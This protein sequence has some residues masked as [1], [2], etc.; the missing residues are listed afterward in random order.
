MIIIL[1]N[2]TGNI[3]SVKNMLNKI[4]I[5]AKVSN[6]LDEIKKAEKVIL[7]GV[8]SFD[9]GIDALRNSDYFETLEEMVLKKKVPFL[10]ICLGMQLLFEKSEEGQLPGLNWIN[11]NVIKFN[12]E[13]HPESNHLKIPHMGWNYIKSVKANPVLFDKVEKE[14]FYFVHSYHVCCERSHDVLAIANYGY[15]F[16]CAVQKDNIFGVQFHPEK[17]HRFGMELL[18]KFVSL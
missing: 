1:D 15:E 7:P 5:D 4:G 16:Q 2:L 8:G 11:G 6:K 17:S 13:N 9:R 14:R 12:F 3:S 10:G 18:K